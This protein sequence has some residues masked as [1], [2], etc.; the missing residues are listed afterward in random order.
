MKSKSIKVFI[1]S[2]LMAVTPLSLAA[3]KKDK[4]SELTKV[5]LN[6]VTRSVFYAPM[7]VSINKG[8]FK[9]EGIGIELSTGQG[10]DGNMVKTQVFL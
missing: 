8:F 3:C 5:R 2:L 10:A 6:E 9:E 1:C 4:N 7:Y